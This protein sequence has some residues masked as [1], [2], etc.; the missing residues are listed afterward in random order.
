M[1]MTP[2]N[3]RGVV[4]RPLHKICSSF[5][6]KV[7]SLLCCCLDS[8]DVETYG[9]NNNNNNKRNQVDVWPCDVDV[10]IGVQ[11]RRKAPELIRLSSCKDRIRDS[12]YV[13]LG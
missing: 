12:D 3:E 13:E 1:I 6:V 2:S 9:I 5:N 11:Q 10:I 4:T 7:S 8:E